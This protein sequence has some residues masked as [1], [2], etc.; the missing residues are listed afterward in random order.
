MTSNRQP[1]SISRTAGPSLGALLIDSALAY[2]ERVALV[3]DG[4]SHTYAD[5]VGRAARIGAVLAAAPVSAPALGAVFAGHTLTSY[6]G[7]VGTLLSGAGY[8]PLNPRFPDAR[9]ATMLRAS[10]ARS[11]VIGSEHL[12]R[13]DALLAGLTAPVTVVVPDLVDTEALASRLAPHVIVGAAALDAASPALERPAVDPGSIGY[14]MFTSGSTGTPRGVGVTHQN[15]LHHLAAMW[16]RYGVTVED[17]LSQTFDL[18]FDL[19]V[20]DMFVAWGRG[21]ALYSVPATDMLAPA[22]FI[23]RTGLTIWFS[24]PSA[25]IVMKNLRLLASGAFPTLRY[26]LF[27]GERLPQ[28]IAEAWQA[29]AP[30]S[31]VE[32]LYGPTEATIACT[33]YRWE[34]QRSPAQCVEGVVPI[35]RPYPG[36]TAAIVDEHLAPVPAGTKGELAVRGPQVTAGYWNDPDKTAERFVAM[37]WDAGPENR[38]YRTGDVAFVGPEGELAFCGRADDQVKIRGFRVDLAEIEHGLRQAAGTEAVAVIPDPKDGDTVTGVLGFVAGREG[39]PPA[40]ILLEVKKL[41]PD[42]MVP[43]ALVMVSELPLNANG[44]VDKRQLRRLA[45]EGPHGHQK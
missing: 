9:N 14:L 28:S 45:E 32:N 3:V 7:V 21:A 11:L 42:Y 16:E 41:L 4:A 34:P 33:L 13:L 5:F 38:W 30:A 40:A 2:G 17:R 19:S 6:L 26:S 31:I 12:G 29:A 39:T 20:F 1:P 24:V 8:V 10:G 37:P 27:C 25:A 18:T 36:M 43:R 22:K 44:K 35:G 23:Q 15:A